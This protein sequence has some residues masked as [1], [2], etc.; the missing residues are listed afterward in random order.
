MIIRLTPTQLRKLAT[1]VEAYTAI[2]RAD[3]AFPESAKPL[4]V[5]DIHLAY[6]F[7]WEDGRQF[8]CEFLDFERDNKSI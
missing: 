6:L 1:Q 3:G 7:W 5:D 2:V 4:K 8:L